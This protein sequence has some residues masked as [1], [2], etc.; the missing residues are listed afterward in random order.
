M[1]TKPVDATVLFDGWE[2]AGSRVNHEPEDLPGELT[3]VPSRAGEQARMKK[4]VQSSRSAVGLGDFLF[5]TRENIRSWLD[6]VL[7]CSQHAGH[8]GIRHSTFR[9]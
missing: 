6:G 7:A 2:G 8:A 5:A 3:I 1:G 4:R 9:C